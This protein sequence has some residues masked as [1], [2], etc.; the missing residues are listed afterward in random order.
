MAIYFI[1]YVNGP[2]CNA[3]ESLNVPHHDLQRPSDFT[4]K[5]IWIIN[6]MNQVVEMIYG[7]ASSTQNWFLK[8]EPA[9]VNTVSSSLLWVPN[10]AHLT[11]TSSLF[12]IQLLHR[13]SGVTKSKRRSHRH[14]F[15]HQ[16]FWKLGRKTHNSPLLFRYALPLGGVSWHLILRGM[17]IHWSIW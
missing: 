17:M 15:V 9:G 11:V 8:L 1:A 6:E 3:M 14:F 16:W 10:N 12:T 13:A 2:F 5:F 7:I 4:A